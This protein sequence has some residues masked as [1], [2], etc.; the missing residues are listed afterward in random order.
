MW[1]GKELDPSQVDQI[2]WCHS[3]LVLLDRSPDHSHM[4]NRDSGPGESVS[5]IV[6]RELNRTKPRVWGSVQVDEVWSTEEE[7]H[8]CPGHFWICKFE[9]VSGNMSSVEKKSQSR[10]WEEYKGTR[11]YDGDR[12]LVVELW[13]YRVADDSSGLTFVGPLTGY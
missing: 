3:V 7:S 9:T 10:K 8:M 6:V 5:E 11:Y 13:L 12:T 4:I 1:E 2:S